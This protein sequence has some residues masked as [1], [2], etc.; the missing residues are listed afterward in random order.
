MIQD[1]P[2]SESRQVPP[3]NFFISYA[4]ADESW[5]VWIAGQLENAGC[6]VFVHAWD[7]R[8]GHN[9]IITIHQALLHHPRVLL[10]VSPHLPQGDL[11]QA[12]WAAALLQDLTGEKRA[13]VPVRVAPCKV[14]GLLAPLQP[15]DLFGL[16]EQEAL[17]RLLA[18]IFTR[19]ARS[20][21]PLPGAGSLAGLFFPGARRPHLH[22]IFQ[23]PDLPKGYVPRLAVYGEIKRHLLTQ[24]GG[25]TTSITTALRG[26]GGFGKTTLAT[27]LCHDPDIQTA[28]PDDIL[29]IELGEQ[30]PEELDLLNRQLAAIEPDHR[31]AVTRE[32]ARESLASCFAQ[33]SDAHR[34]R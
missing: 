6:R 28:F 10:I 5:A 12:E 30:P 31:P 25:Q 24:L 20:V 17:A 16:S 33:S 23:A 11:P 18:G 2:E 26:A 3:P 8:P 14:G 19:R 9:I 34:H 15:L 22:R 29:W 21:D 27:A 4:P 32:E 1:T 13:L 7:L